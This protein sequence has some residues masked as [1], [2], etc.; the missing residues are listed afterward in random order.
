M[1]TMQPYEREGLRATPRRTAHAGTWLTLW[2]ILIVIEA[3][4]LSNHAAADTWCWR[5]TRWV[6]GDQDAYVAANY[7]ASQMAA[8]TTP[9]TEPF[10]IRDPSPFRARLYH[11]TENMWRLFRDLG[12]PYMLIGVIALVWIYDRRG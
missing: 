10:Y 8:A 6:M 12:E 5:T 3:L 9:A 2:A 7:R 4:L 1:R 11:R